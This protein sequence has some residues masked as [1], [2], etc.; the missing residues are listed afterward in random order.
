MMILGLPSIPDVPSQ[1]SISWR[2]AFLHRMITRANTGWCP[3]VRCG[4][5]FHQ[6][7]VGRFPK[8]TSSFPHDV[9]LPWGS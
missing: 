4:K 9:S 8:G 7:Q 1:I 5:T 2:Q 3:Q 6:G